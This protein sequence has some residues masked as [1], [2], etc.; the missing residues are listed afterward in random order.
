MYLY[1]LQHVLFITGVG[2]PA[3]GPLASRHGR[4]GP[5]TSTGS[6]GTSAPE[7]GLILDDVGPGPGTGTETAGAGTPE[8]GLIYDGAG[9]GPSTGTET[10]GTGNA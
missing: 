8:T 5:D 9:P 1:M 4:I 7:T 3:P 2:A 6:T 10:A